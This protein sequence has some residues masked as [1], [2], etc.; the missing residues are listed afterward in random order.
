MSLTGTPSAA[1]NTIRARRARPADIAVAIAIFGYPASAFGSY[2][3]LAMSTESARDWA[4][5]LTALGVLIVTTTGAWFFRRQL[6]AQT[7]FNSY[8]EDVRTY[9]VDLQHR[10][11]IQR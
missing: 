5:G 1:N 4:L 10:A 8:Y 6:P 9:P 11:P 7:L 2:L 3:Q